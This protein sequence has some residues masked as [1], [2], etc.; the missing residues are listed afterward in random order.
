MNQANPRPT[1]LT[2][3]QPSRSAPAPSQY[4]DPSRDPRELTLSELLGV[5]GGPIIQNGSQ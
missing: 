5:A 3:L 1:C 4:D 2:P